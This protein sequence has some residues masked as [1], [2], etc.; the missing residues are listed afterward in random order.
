MNL[1]KKLNLLALSLLAACSSTPKVAEETYSFKPDFRSIA[2]VDET[3]S[4]LSAE[5]VNKTIKGIFHSYLLGQVLL[6][7][8]DKSLDQD[9]SSAMGSDTYNE[10]QA[11]RIMVDEFEEHMNDLYVRLVMVSALPKFDDQQKLKAHE[12]L[13]M[14]G[15]FLEGITGDQN[16]LP[17]NLKP[18]I[19]GNLREKQTV[20]Y[21]E[22]KAIRDDSTITN[23]DQ[24]VIAT[25][26]QN[27][28]LLRGTRMKYF[29]NLMNYKVDEKIL[30]QTL[31]DQKNDHDFKEFRSNVKKM[32]KEIKKFTKEISGGRSTSSDTIFPNAGAAGNITGRGFPANTWSLTYD[33]GPGGKTSP[34]VLQNLKDRNMKATFFMLA[35]Q[36]E[37]LPNTAKSIAD[38][39]MDIAS[40]SYDHAQLTKVGPIA[41]E[42]QIGGAKK[43]IET[44]LGKQVKLFRL[45]Y[46]AGVSVASIRAKIAE[47]K[48]IHVFWNVD[49]LDW[50][51]KNPTSIFNRS[52]KQMAASPKNNGVILFHDIHQ[53][54]VVASTMLMDYFKQ[55]NINVCTVQAVVDQLN[56]GLENCQP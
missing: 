4:E 18:L 38:A 41:L 56:Q 49:T 30:S 46:G 51:D 52:V 42:K 9:P 50:Q 8:F 39:G 32:S 40:H 3:K 37:G 26:N 22:L 15:Q 44:R 53:Q 13:K 24:E 6:Q 10:L 43:I 25:I 35:K 23:N 11:I 21:D 20:L 17:E 12:S 55:Q 7:D 2:S 27:M 5:K 19:L 33:D 34:V 36:V 16:Q 1:W 48:L 47:H 14:I 54:S 31:A 28:V 29:K 45:P